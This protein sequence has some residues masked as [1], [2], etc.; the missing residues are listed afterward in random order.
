MCL[1][2]SYKFLFHFIGFVVFIHASSAVADVNNV[3]ITTTVDQ[4]ITIVLTDSIT[5]LPN[6]VTATVVLDS[7]PANGQAQVRTDGLSVIYTPN[8][9]FTGEDTFQYSAQR[10]DEITDGP[11]TITVVVGGVTFQGDSPQAAV[12][13]IF[14]KL[15]LDQEPTG[16]LI[17]FCQPYLA[18][19][20]SG[21]PEDLRELLDALSPKQIIAQSDLGS[22]MARQQVDS[23]VK[24]LV[25]LRKGMTQAALGGLA[26]NVGDKSFTWDE[27][28]GATGGAASADQPTSKNLG[29]Y[30]NGN[31]NYGGTEE[32]EKEDAYTFTSGNLTTGLDY[33]FARGTVVGGALGVGSTTMKIDSNG[34]DMDVSGATGTFYASFFPTQRLNIDIIQSFNTQE[35]S[36]TRRIIVGTIDDTAEGSTKSSLYM[37]SLAFG[38]EAFNVGSFTWSLALRGD[39]L[40]STINGYQETGDTDYAYIFDKRTVD[41]INSDLNNSFTYASSYKW[42]VMVHQFDVSWIYHLKN[43]PETIRFASILAPE[44][45]DEFTTDPMDSNYFKLA[46]GLQ[47]IW[48]GGN[49]LYFQ[50]QTTL[51]KEHYYDV[52]LAAGFRTEF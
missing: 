9:G 5:N 28:R 25:A 13:D 10:S 42:G 19:S 33:R 17:D 44:D 21:A 52:G 11:A 12:D 24:R 51:A 35:F 37:S 31:V 2:R 47:S 45:F 3:T 29:W 20:Q 39:Y 6:G 36:T 26:F 14:T 46:Y 48:A 50:L 32:T 4:A 38:Y 43:D 1:S 34:G 7:Q 41:Q 27:L 40:K 18:A 49:T 23:V 30:I 22:D 8:A 15:C 16:E